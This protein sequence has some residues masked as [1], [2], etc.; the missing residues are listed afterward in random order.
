[1]SQ[2]E[3]WEGILGA[4]MANDDEQLKKMLEK[5]KDHWTVVQEYFLTVSED[6][7][8]TGFSL[9]RGSDGDCRKTMRFLCM[10][11]LAG[12]RRAEFSLQVVPGGDSAKEVKAHQGEDPIRVGD[13]HYFTMPAVE[14]ICSKTGQRWQA[15]EAP[16][17]VAVLKRIGDGKYLYDA[18]GF[19]NHCDGLQPYAGSPLQRHIVQAWNGN[20]YVMWSPAVRTRQWMK[21]MAD[22]TDEAAR[23]QAGLRSGTKPVH[24]LPGGKGPEG[25]VEDFHWDFLH[26]ILTPSKTLLR[27]IFRLLASRFGTAAADALRKRIHKVL[28]IH[29]SARCERP[30]SGR[31]YWVKMAVHRGGRAGA[32][33]VDLWPHLLGAVGDVLPDI[34]PDSARLLVAL[35]RMM[36]LFAD[37]SRTL[38]T[39]DFA[40]FKRGCESYMAKTCA[41]LEMLAS[42]MG[43]HVP[44]PSMMY[45]RDVVPAILSFC[46]EKGICASELAMGGLEELHGLQNLMAR[47]TGV[48]VLRVGAR[49][50]T[51]GT[52][53]RVSVSECL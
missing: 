51:V 26:L 6:A 39:R 53:E 16:A 3:V 50:V 2:D 47:V 5:W 38:A 1:M 7:H 25:L 23:T 42:L 28:K 22:T 20:S 17:M 13:T 44:T 34:D 21:A 10:P 37:T 19:F 27:E 45:R 33:M 35:E 14:H 8:D 41:W 46:L 12:W 18:C 40:E 29:V 49:G 43:P 48:C 15:D 32:I 11:W 30:H 31:G 52:R 9:H 24:M 36:E 4:S